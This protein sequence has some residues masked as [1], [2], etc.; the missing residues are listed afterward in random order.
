FLVRITDEKGRPVENLEHNL[1]SQKYPVK[2]NAPIKKI[3]NFAEKYFEEQIKLN[4]EHMENYLLLADTYL[5]NDKAT[6]AE[7]VLRKAIE[8]MPESVLFKNHI[9]EAYIRAEK[10]DEITSTSEKIY[11]LY[12]DVPDILERKYDE[13]WKNENIEEAEK[14]VARFDEL[15]PGSSVSQ[16]MKMNILFKKGD[17]E[18]A[19]LL[20]KNTFEKY[21]KNWELAYLSAIFSIRTT[22]SYKDAIEI[23][24][25]FL[26]KHRFNQ[27]YIQLGNAYLKDADIDNFESSLNEIFKKDPSATGI[28]YSLAKVFLQLQKY[29]KAEKYILKSLQLCP[30]YSEYWAL[31][32][33][34]KQR[35][36]ATADAVNYYKKALLYNPA[37]YDV[38][39]R[40]RELNGENNIFNHF[41]SVDIHSLIKDAPTSEEYPESDGVFLL[42]DFKRV[43]YPGGSSETMKEIVIKVFNAEGIEDFK[44]YSVPHNSYNEDLIIEKAV[45]IKPEGTEI[46]ADISN[47]YIV[48]KSIEPNDFL[49]I[50]WKKRNYYRGRL[51]HHIWEEINFNYFYPV[52][53]IR[54]SI[55]VPKDFKFNYKTQNMDIN[56][57]ISEN[58]D[59]ELYKWRLTDQ[60]EIEHE[61]AMPDLDDIGK[62]LFVSSIPDWEYLVDW[63]LDLAATKTRTSYEIKEKVKELLRSNENATELEKI[64][65]IYYYITDNINYSSVS[66]RQSGLIPQKAR[67]VLVQKIGDCKDMATLC[68]AMLNEA[69]VSSHYVLVNTFFEGKNKNILPSIEFNHAIV[70]AETENGIIYM[71]LTAKNYPLFTVPGSD[72]DAFALS[73]TPKSKEPFYLTSDNFTKGDTRRKSTVKLNDDNSA[74]IIRN[75][76]RT[77]IAGASLRNTYRYMGKKDQM[78]ELT[79]VLSDDFPNVK[80]D[81]F[82][83][84]NINQ[85]NSQ[86][87]Y[88]YKFH[89]P[90]YLESAGSM[91][92]L[93]LPW[94]DGLTSKRAISYE[95]RN[96][97]LYYRPSSDTLLE[98]LEVHLPKGFVPIELQNK[99]HYSCKIAEYKVTMS[100]KKGILKAVRKFINKKAIVSIDEYKE[101]KEFYNKAVRADSQPILLKKK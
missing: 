49:Y 75:S 5:R 45:V 76:C 63:Y 17:F 33:E 37:E 91:K 61:Y 85:I 32:G 15:L 99:T 52:K 67:D 55:L 71:D 39:E 44:E 7:Q 10:Y 54:Y 101:F 48:F 28:Y 4:P 51:A 27:A 73:I 9:I 92:L 25:K 8:L 24:K 36:G 29:N 35:S 81:S 96:F 57:E 23:Y 95:K 53:D 30:N 88:F 14:I 80:L 34:I 50:K 70:G 83:I 41:E 87:N 22:N 43:V 3:R 31:L 47:N 77:G 98:E 42:E 97:E 100:F 13:Y 72:V 84:E 93:K 11:S 64:E 94:G 6:E 12:P 69:G 18:A 62:M 86:T 89:V 20:L 79:E 68:I 65:L 78:K 46:K 90:H 40:L 74:D 59:G 38:R 58:G 26:K 82:E 16:L 21:P 60:P 19:L 1:E 56:P 2:P 66:F